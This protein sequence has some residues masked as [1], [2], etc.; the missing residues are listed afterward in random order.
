MLETNNFENYR[1]NED[2]YDGLVT[3][4]EASQ[5]KSSWFIAS[6]EQASLQEQII[7]QYEAELLPSIPC[8]RITVDRQEPSLRGQLERLVED[9]PSLQQPNAKAVISVTNIRE[10][11][12]IKLDENEEKSPVEKFFG[13]LQ[14]TREGL[15]QFPYPIVLWVTPQILRRL[16]REAPDF[17]SWRGGVFRFNNIEDYQVKE[18]GIDRFNVAEIRE[19][20]SSFLLPLEELEKQIKA[21]K[22]QSDQSPA[23]ATLYDRVGQ[24][25]AKRVASGE[26]ENLEEDIE[27]GIEFYQKSIELA[28]RLE[29]KTS[30]CQ[31]L[32]RLGRFYYDLSRYEEAKSIY[33]QGLDIAREINYKHGERTALNGLGN[34][35]Y[36]L[37]NYQQAID[38]HQQSL[39][40]KQKIGDRKGEANSYNNLGLVYQKLGEYQQAID[41]HK[42][43]LALK[44][45]IGD[46]KGEANSYNNLGLVY[47]KL[48][49]YQQAI[50]YLQQS[51]AI[52]QEIGNRRGKAESYISLGNVYQSLGEYQQAIDYLQ[53]SLAIYKGIGDRK[54]EAYSY[55]GLGNIHDLLNNCQQ[56]IYFYQQS[57]AIT[58][59]ITNRNGEA[60]SYI[61]LGNIYQSLEEYQQAIDYLQQSLVIAREIGHR[62]VEADSL[63]NLGNT[64]TKLKRNKEA[65]D[66][67]KAARQLFQNMGLNNKVKRC[68]D[69]I[70]AIRT[71][72][73]E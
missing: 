23:L 58:K 40:L 67:Y 69:A 60:H 49:E 56:A 65:L 47:Q 12:M 63:F 31:T 64:Y 66:N 41:Y 17:W 61:G 62:Q 3:L 53:Q 57:L 32:I 19:E 59:E 39:A 21:I 10:I 38:Y 54:G 16:S 13:Y 7:R 36:S 22:Q 24:V 1:T 37:G 34:V 48:G 28:E 2:S 71:T 72:S 50:D 14:W 18:V 44:Q 70:Q 6:C 26:S 35:Y 29:L 25:Y 5:G 4:I 73:P 52:K 46:R 27:K 30:L 20:E 9:N 11:L 15:R 55:I 43:S 45:K 8:Y 33:Q 51:L 42:Q 68:D